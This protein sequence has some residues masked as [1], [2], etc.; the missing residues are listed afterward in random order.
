MAIQFTRNGRKAMLWAQVEAM[1]RGDLYVEPEHLLLGL[2]H[3]EGTGALRL[4]DRMS[5]SGSQVKDAIALRMPPEAAGARVET[6]QLSPGAKKIVEQARQETEDAGEDYVGTEHLM[7]AVLFGLESVGSELT[8]VL[9]T[10]H[11]THVRAAVAI[12]NVS[13]EPPM[14]VAEEPVPPPPPRITPRPGFLKGR[15]LLSVS[16]LSTA[17]I[18]ALFELT[19]EIKAGRGFN[20]AAKGKTLAL[21][22]EKPS[23]RTRVTFGVAMNRLGGHHMYLGPQEVGLGVRESVADVGR[24]LSRWVDAVAI[25]TFDDARVQ[26]F[27]EA[28][29][30]P[31]INAL[32]D[33]EHPCQAFADFYT[34]LE[35]RSETAGMKLVFVGDGNNVAH[36]LMLLAPCLGTHF[37]LCCPEG[38]EPDSEILAKAQ[39]LAQQ[40]NTNFEISRDPISASDD[41]DVLYT[42]V[43]TSMGQEAE[44][45]K[46]LKDFMGFQVG[47]ELIREAKDDVLV[48]H[49]LPAHRGEEIAGDVIDGPH[50]GVFD[51]AENRLHVQQALLAAVL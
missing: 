5:L 44:Q 42:D 51:Q 30:I 9:A 40:Y 37:T 3:G 29:D 7:L 48:L 47:Q 50:S 19:R 2:L 49:C 13:P 22:F 1:R 46:R 32:T 12:K 14:N 18:R 23:L 36:S 27:A 17:E 26:E 38:Y 4:L 6:S 39:A 11:L 24:G 20:E 43:W 33:R 41:A 35:S 28:A 34:I 31:V 10:L 15:D 8:G 45:E 16:D 25:R 21:L